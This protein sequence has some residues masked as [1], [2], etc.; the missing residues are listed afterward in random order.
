MNNSFIKFLVAFCFIV[1]MFSSCKDEKGE[2]NQLT[3]TEK[4]DGLKNCKM[5]MKKF[6]DDFKLLTIP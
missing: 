4:K 3:E 1:C 6:F 5:L 2:N